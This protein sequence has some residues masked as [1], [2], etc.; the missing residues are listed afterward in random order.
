MFFKNKYDAQLK[1]LAKKTWNGLTEKITFT[2]ETKLFST[3]IPDN[4]EEVKVP[5]E[6]V[7]ANETPKQ[8][9][10][11]EDDYKNRF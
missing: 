1:Q 8:C 5:E 7:C 9:H 6:F 2:K 10:E 3:N 11:A 4:A